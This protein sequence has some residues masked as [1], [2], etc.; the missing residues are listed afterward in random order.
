MRRSLR[1]GIVGGSIAGLS[2]AA[3]LSRIGADVVVLERGPAGF[4]TRRGGLGVSPQLC[5]ALAATQD[6][7]LRHVVHQQRR[8]WIRGAEH[9]EAA[10]IAVTSYGILWRWLRAQLPESMVEFG[11]TVALIDGQTARPRVTTTDARSQDFDLVVAADGGGSEA[12]RHVLADDAHAAFAGYVLW[13]GLV[14]FAALDDRTGIYGGRL[15]IANRGDQ[16]F[17]GYAIPSD[18][19]CCAAMNWG[20]YLPTDE[21]ALA[22]LRAGGAVRPP[23][24]LERCTDALEAFVR[25]RA[26]SREL[27]PGWVEQIIDRTIACG[28]IA[29]H[30][31]YEFAASAMVRGRVVLV[32]N[33]AHLA[34]PITGSGGRMAMEDALALADALVEHGDVDAA[35]AQFSQCR[36]REGAALVEQ[37]RQR[38]AAFRAT[39]PRRTA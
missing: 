38:G 31:V 21:A 22:E 27:W 18:E 9:E 3:A 12:R 15:L 16:H 33:A 34:S 24:Q 2:V 20:W 32:G 10:N 11:Q 26:A 14:P 19:S 13:R 36:T 8:L 28:T 25:A 4:A 29:P 39:T 23:H 6:G 17:V 30:P 7:M 5:R 35:L 37:G 1:V